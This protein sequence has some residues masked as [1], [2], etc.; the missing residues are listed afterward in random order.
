[1]SKQKTKPKSVSGMDRFEDLIPNLSGE[2]QKQ[3]EI[4]RKEIKSN[5]VSEKD[6]VVKTTTVVDSTTVVETPIV[7]DTTTVLEDNTVEDPTTVVD[8]TTVNLSPV[9]DP[10]TVVDSPV[11]L[12]LTVVDST[13]VVDGN[14]VIPSGTDKTTTVVETDTVETTTVV[15]STTPENIL[16]KLEGIVASQALSPTAKILL[17]H[18]ILKNKNFKFKF[19]YRQVNKELGIALKTLTG[20]VDNIRAVDNVYIYSNSNKGTTIDCSKGFLIERAVLKSSTPDHYRSSNYL[21]DKYNNKIGVYKNA[22]AIS[23]LAIAY[24]LT[25]QDFSCPVLEKLSKLDTETVALVFAYT[26]Q[27]VSTRKS[28]RAGY[29]FR[30]AEK[31][32]FGSLDELSAEIAEEKAKAIALLEKTKIEDLGRKELLNLGTVFDKTFSAV[33]T[34]EEIRSVILGKIKQ[35][36]ELKSVFERILSR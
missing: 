30:T 35:A 7:N 29:I 18:L 17:F 4:Y 27:K 36:D 23:L 24:G 28:S 31:S 2:L 21:K 13:T 3:S 25:K 5:T 1:M 11:S 33:Q 26:V 19:S 12:L 15:A 34:T 9:V 22:T 10:T 8:S 16:S 32:Y 14:T 6:T 20:A